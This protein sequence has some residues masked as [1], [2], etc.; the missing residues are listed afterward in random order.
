MKPED[1]IN[2][3]RDLCHN[4]SRAGGWWN[5]LATGAPIQRNVGEMLALIHSEISEALEG[6]RKNLN[7]DHLPHRKMIEVEMADAVIRIMDFCGGLGLDIGGALIEKLNYNA[8]REDHKREA[9]MK[10]G[11][12]TI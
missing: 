2:Q 3:I 6:H 5:D 12:K 7:D 9:R 4:Q 11:G 1:M 8:H 10:A